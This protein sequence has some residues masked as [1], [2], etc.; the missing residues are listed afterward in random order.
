MVVAV[1]SQEV[2]F[3]RRLVAGRLR[4]TCLLLEWAGDLYERRRPFVPIKRGQAIERL[5]HQL[6]LRVLE[7]VSRR[8]SARAGPGEDVLPHLLDW[9]NV[10]L[11]R[12]DGHSSVP[13]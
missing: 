13:I 2:L 9:A 4:V 10:A 6:V 5:P 7:R 3:R 8:V 11:D 1:R 12:V